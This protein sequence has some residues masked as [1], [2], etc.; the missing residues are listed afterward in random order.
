MTPSTQE[1]L[2]SHLPALRLLMLLGW[3]YLPPQCIT[4]MRGS[5]RE[6]LLKPLLLDWLRSYRFEYKGTQHGLSS[7][8]MEQ[9]LRTLQPTLKDG[10]L[11]ANESVYRHLCLGITIT[12]FMPDGNKH[13]AT[14]PLLDWENPER[15]RFS[16]TDEYEVLSALGTLTRRPDLV[17]FVNGIPMAVLEAKRPD[18]GNPN[19]SM[20]L[21]GI[22]QN[23]RNQR[24]DEIPTLFAYAQLLFS[25]SMDDGKYATTHTPA[26]FWHRWRE[27]EFTTES[28]LA[29]KNSQLTKEQ[30]SLLLQGRPQPVCEYALKLWKGEQVCNAQDQLLQSLLTPARLL[31]FL[32]LSILF[33]RKNQKI[34][35]RYQQFFSIQ[36][37]LARVKSFTPDG[38]RQGGVVWH[39]TGSGK[40]YTM[41]LLCKALLLDEALQNCRI[42]VV[43]DR[44]DLEDQLANTFINGGAF[45]SDIATKKEGEHAKV[46]S[47]TDLARRIGKGSERILFSLIHKFQSASRLPECRNDSAD[48][49]VLVDE[50]HRSHGGETH[51]RMRKALPNAAYVAFTGTPL[52][53]DHKTTNKFGSIVHAYS[54]QRAVEDGAVTPLLYEERKPELEINEKAV[55]TAFDNLTLNLSEAQ[56]ADLKKKFANKGAIYG[57]LG[58]IEL[59]AWDIAKHFSEN[60]KALGVGLKGQ[61]AT[62]SKLDAVRYHQVLQTTGLVSSAIIIS[63]PDTREGN[64]DVDE[65]SIPE[66]QKW[67]KATVGNDASTYEKQVLQDFAGDGDPDLLIVV[68]RLLTGFDEPRN[69]VLYIDKSLKE[70]GIIQAIA[71][72]NRLHEHKKFG[73]LIDYR[74]ILKELDT[75]MRQYQDLEQQTQQGYDV[76]DLD[77]LYQSVSVEYKRLPLLHKNLWNL[78]RDVRNRYDFEQFRILL[79]PKEKTTEEGV[80]FDSNQKRREDFYEALTQFGL[81]LQVALASRSFHEDQTFSERLVHEY[82][83][84]LAFFTRLRWAS[85]QDA[86]ETVDYSS[87]E[88][89]I[90]R[91]VDKQVLGTCVREP[92]GVYVVNE[93]GKTEEPDTWS[94]EKTRNETDIIRSRVKKSIEQDLANDPYAQKVF[95]ELLRKAIADAESLF[96]HP[97]QQYALFKDFADKLGR[98]E[99]TGMPPE[100]DSNPRARAYFGVLKMAQGESAIDIPAFVDESHHID[101]VIENALAENSLNPGGVETSVRKALLPDL[102]KRF[103]LEKA[104]D[105]LEQLLQIVRIDL[106]RKN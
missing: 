10:L 23:L 39:T 83:N 1:L 22:S 41:V 68:D 12:E 9:V 19:K 35:A 64:T 42:L 96:D 56:K 6:V 70:H 46:T 4:P 95:A 14:V 62:S 20:I 98:R 77:G 86:G 54:M 13:N 16:V 49:I 79:I 17:C 84:D 28:L 80:A 36:A 73:F 60:F 55:N 38:A 32:R 63:P 7:S 40:S 47:G 53:K 106:E 61:I 45:G 44:I 51:E 72:V 105:I 29:I 21:E 97:F 50:G 65:A 85:R 5:L 24:E 89:Q 104:K 99:L 74:G 100:L 3:D 8:G 37:L 27:E 15:N 91:M 34:A 81:C 102:F 33:D 43:T 92:Q 11:K 101:T 94:E 82:K 59:I 30:M 57:A 69:A 66:V 2:T 78:F 48:L 87:Y 93:L 67:Y 71:R 31:E 90:R 26:T 76:A 25:I 18:S 88:I 75:A 103:G 52:L 58:R